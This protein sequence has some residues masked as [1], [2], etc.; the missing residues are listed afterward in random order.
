MLMA[1]PVG[2]K[3][4][5]RDR[6]SAGP[7]DRARSVGAVVVGAVVALLNLPAVASVGLR[8][9]VGAHLRFAA[10]TSLTGKEWGP[11][12]LFE[13]STIIVRSLIPFDGLSRL[14][15]ALGHR[16]TIWDVSGMIVMLGFAVILSQVVYRRFVP[17]V[18][19][20]VDRAAPAVA[21]GLTVAALVAAPVTVFTW[22]RHQ[23]LDGYISI[24][25]Y[26][27]PSVN[28]LRPIA[29]ILF[30]V[31]MDR[32]FGRSRGTVVAMTAALSLLA[33]HA[34]P[35][36]TVCLLP[37]LILLAAWERWR[38]RRLD[39][40]LWG[41]GFVLP[42]LVGLGY[43]A[44]VSRGQGSI[45]FAPFDIIR[46]VLEARGMSPWVFVPL[47]MLSMLFPLTV[48]V[49]CWSDARRTASWT[50][51]WITFG[52]GILLFCTFTVTER[53]DYGDLIWGPQVALFIVFVESIVLVAPRVLAPGPDGRRRLT[54]GSAVVVAALALHV[55]SGAMLWYQEVVHPAAWW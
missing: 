33:L 43:Q 27:N 47:L 38:G 11:Y 24:T 35:S 18:A 3:P 15:P 8:T 28:V 44:V 46:G 19:P 4:E 49:M 51:A 32:L 20:V 31:L 9:D 10:A 16:A 23:L 21:G 40:R 2:P 54:A 45:G 52:I 1:A 39:W 41:L 17:T 37:A 13:Q 55:A 6:S 36:Y 34:K 50:T 53:R 25:S 42:S 22:S 5:Q 29:L 26:E 30:W 7:T 14:F 48:A 12:S